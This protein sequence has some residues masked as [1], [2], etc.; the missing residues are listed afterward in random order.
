MNRLN[1]AP[2]GDA[3]LLGSKQIQDT[4]EEIARLKELVIQSNKKSEEK[5]SGPSPPSPPPPPEP[6]PPSNF[7][8][9]IGPPPS[10][11]ATFSSSQDINDLID[12]LIRSPRF[13][14]IIKKSN[15]NN[16]N[17]A[18]FNL[19]SVKETFGTSSENLLIFILVLITLFLF[20][21]LF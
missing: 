18:N 3:F 9:R 14:D 4:Q 21:N 19:E 6:A 16:T 2:L 13:Q 8:Q 12:R 17:F 10:Q 5:L 20:F 1:F 7:Y 11:Y 15:E